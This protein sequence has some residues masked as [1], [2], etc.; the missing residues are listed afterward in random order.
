MKA[1]LF[2]PL[3]AAWTRLTGLFARSA[4]EAARWAGRQSWSRLALLG[5]LALFAQHVLTHNIL[6]WD[7]DSASVHHRHASRH[8][9]G[10]SGPDSASPAAADPA[11]PSP[12]AATIAK[13]EPGSAEE[14]HIGWDGITVRSREGRISV[15][16]DGPAPPVTGDAAH[17]K[18]AQTNPAPISP[19]PGSAASGSPAPGSAASGIAASRSPVQASPA[20]TSA[21]PKGMTPAD[22]PDARDADAK[23]ADANAEDEDEDTTSVDASQPTWRTWLRDA[24]EGLVLLVI[25]YLL[26]AR[27]VMREAQKSEARATVAEAQAAEATTQ[28]AAAEASAEREALR[29]QLAQAQLQTLQAQ[30]EPHFLFNTLASVE[31]LIETDPPRAAAMQRHLIQYLRSALPQMRDSG[32]QLGREMDL[33]GAYLEILKVRME[34]RLQIDLAVP[35]GLRSAEFPPMLLQSLVE[36]AIRHGLEPKAEGG[37]VRVSA[38]IEDGALVVAVT[39]T[40]IGLTAGQKTAGSGLGLRNIAERLALLYPGQASTQLVPN[41]PMGAQA[42]VRL[43]YR[44]AS[45][46]VGA[47]TGDIWPAGEVRSAGEIRT[48]GGTLSADGAP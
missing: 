17:A 45:T 30:V 46:P 32:S 47:S 6:Q 26:A 16:K 21:T 38:S 11:K 36:N 41:S 5:L 23:T 13:T 18:L 31:Y 1:N 42:T 34:D 28:A 15:T 27:L 20:Q 10:H 40:G 22:R 37:I 25:L 9:S 24:L 14:V 19:A 35:E 39:D 7:E 44:V 29:F 3:Q 8:P 33:V 43:P 4:R 48:T 2:L 12:D